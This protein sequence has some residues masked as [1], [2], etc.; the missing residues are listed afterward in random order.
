[1]GRL[2]RSSRVDTANRAALHRLF[3]ALLDNAFKYSHPGGRARVTVSNSSTQV[4]VS[5]EDS[6]VGIANQSRPHIFKRF[7]RG[8]PSRT[9]PGHGLGL[10]LAETIAEA[11][12]ATI[13]VE[14]TPGVGSRFDV[15]FPARGAKPASGNLQISAV[16]STFAD[17]TSRERSKLK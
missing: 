14:S 4:R 8:D 3:L 17:A 16:L 5:F 12:G 6:G 15:V 10:S 1:M 11:H 2:T 13:E 7:Y 9:G